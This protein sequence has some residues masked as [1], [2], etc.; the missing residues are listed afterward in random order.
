M[1]AGHLARGPEKMLSKVK[2]NKRPCEARRCI[3]RSFRILLFLIL[4]VTKLK[5][6]QM[7]A[8]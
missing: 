6:K 5:A 3:E 2:R 7:V 4:Y 1:T 8:F